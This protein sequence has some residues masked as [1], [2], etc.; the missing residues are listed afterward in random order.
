[1][2]PHPKKSKSQ[3]HLSSLQ[4]PPG[5]GFPLVLWHPLWPFSPSL[6]PLQ[7]HGPPGCLCQTGTCLTC[8]PSAW[9]T[10]PRYLHDWSPRLLKSL[11]TCL[12]CSSAFPDHLRKQPYPHCLCPPSLL[13]CL[14]YHFSPSNIIYVYLFISFTVCI[15]PLECKC[16]E[17]R[18]VFVLFRLSKYL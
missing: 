16:H 9:D 3:G 1:M 6:L 2:V 4:D 11:L 10:V 15:L 18:D 13:Y 17:D 7:P 8:W 14:V 12:L 5:F